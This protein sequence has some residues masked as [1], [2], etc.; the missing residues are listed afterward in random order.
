MPIRRETPDCRLVGG[1][2]DAM[3][4]RFSLGFGLWMLAGISASAQD[5]PGQTP[6]PE[7]TARDA[8]R[9]VD[10]R[11]RTVAV[12]DDGF[13]LTEWSESS[14]GEASASKS[15]TVTDSSAGNF[16]VEEQ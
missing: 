5:A 8:W 14:E 13:E 10:C 4:T 7:N 2:E 12:R 15:S 9:G 3:R 1:V 16:P 6:T 11:I